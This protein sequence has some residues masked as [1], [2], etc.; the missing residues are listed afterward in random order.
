M[1]QP[2]PTLSVIIPAFNEEQYLP[3][4]L[5]SVLESI[6][7]WELGSGLRSEVIVVDN[8]ST[9]NTAQIARAF[10]ARVVHEPVAGIGRARNTG[11]ASASGAYLVFVDADVHFPIEG[12]TE[13]I[14]SLDTGR[15]VGGAVPPLYEPT[16][17]GTRLLVAAWALYRRFYGGAQGVT[18]FCTRSAF[19]ELNGYRPD[20][21][22]SEDVE[23]FARLSRHGQRTGAPIRHL[24]DL[25]VRPSHR[26]FEQWPSWRMIL[27]ANPV[28]AH[29]FLSSRRF[30]RNWYDRT[31][32]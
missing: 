20:L 7:R 22:M 12:I 28:T 1:D 18:Q 16:K 6:G 24:T 27:W 21:F 14:R 31:V 32:R 29:L 13:I 30:W 8:A 5:P 25:R 9:D 11:A 10:G 19:T 2:A 17:T 26:R 23:F 3:C 15:C 4:Y